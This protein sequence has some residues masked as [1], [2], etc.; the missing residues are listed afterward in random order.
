MYFYIEKCRLICHFE[1]KMRERA[2]KCRSLKELAG[3]RVGVGRSRGG[4]ADLRDDG[5]PQAKS[6]S[7]Q[8][9]SRA[10][11]GEKLR[12]FQVNQVKGL[13][14][15]PGCSHQA[16]REGPSAHGPLLLITVTHPVCRA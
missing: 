14:R 13:Q 16:E 9:A 12:I 5:E 8:R 3:G 7:G 2:R 15:Q 6:S 11:E 10:W 4:R 1:N